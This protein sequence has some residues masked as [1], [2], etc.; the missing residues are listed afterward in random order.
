LE[1][2]LSDNCPKYF[3]L[4]GLI[5]TSKTRLAAYRKGLTVPYET[6]GVTMNICQQDCNS[7]YF[8]A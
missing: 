4:A 3:L 6:P 1:I 5:Y 7:S 8:C 2:I